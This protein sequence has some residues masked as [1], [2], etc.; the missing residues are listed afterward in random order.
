MQTEKKSQNSPSVRCAIIG[1]GMGKFHFEGY[2]QAE[3]ATVVAVADLQEERLLPYKEK[4]GAEACF[5]DY[6]KM[7]ETVQPDLV[8]VALPNRLHEEVT[9]AALEGG[10]HVLCEKPMAMN[11]EQARRMR[12]AARKHDRQL[13]INLNQLYSGKAETLK[14]WISNDNLGEIYHG[15]TCWTRQDGIPGFGGWFGQK[16][17]SGGGPL[18]DLG[19][20]RLAVALWLMGDPEPERVVGYTHHHF[21]L[22]RA[23]AEGKPFDVEDFA[24]GSIR[25][26]NGASLFLE[27][28]WDGFQAKRDKIEMRLQGSRGA[29]E[30]LGEMVHFGRSGAVFHQSLLTPKQP[31]FAT[32]YDAMVQSLRGGEPF[33]GTPERGIAIQQ[34]LDA[35]YRSAGEGREAAVNGME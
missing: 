4:L 6:R 24:A 35:L 1:L 11:V 25:F 12:E 29:L 23:K 8:S 3:G 21:G 32:S 31:A 10:A 2:A 18:I 28:S 22:P 14:E 33:R 20:H 16:A 19:V 9:L 26:K 5:T 7:L 17:M 13:G 15:F 27:A 30:D 34:I